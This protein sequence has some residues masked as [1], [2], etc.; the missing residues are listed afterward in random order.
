M[1]AVLHAKAL[2]R[3]AI[4]SGPGATAE[5]AWPGT[6]AGQRFIDHNQPTLLEAT[7]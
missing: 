6:A 7:S 1:A 4:A 3:Y 5:P 2:N